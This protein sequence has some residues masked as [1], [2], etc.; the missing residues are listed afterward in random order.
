[1]WRGPV[2]VQGDD[3][4]A[5][6]AAFLDGDDHSGLGMQPVD[7]SEEHLTFGFGACCMKVRRTMS[8]ILKVV[9]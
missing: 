7:D 6:P 5:A 4:A 8:T 2:V 3:V 9:S 1:M